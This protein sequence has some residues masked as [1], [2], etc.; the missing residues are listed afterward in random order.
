M[1]VCASA[2]HLLRPASQEWLK[3]FSS[4]RDARI[5]KAKEENAAKEQA[6]TTGPVGD[7]SWEKVESMIDFSF[8]PPQEKESERQRFKQLLQ[9]AKAK[10]VPCEM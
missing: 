9:Q 7:T 1:D 2:C 6:A 4:D 10:N 8:K 5:A 3:K